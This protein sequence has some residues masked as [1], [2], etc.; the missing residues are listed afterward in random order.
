MDQSEVKNWKKNLVRL[1]NHRGPHWPGYH[2][3]VR[4]LMN[5]ADASLPANASPQQALQALE[6]VTDD[7]S[8]GIADGS[9]RPYEDRLV[10]IVQ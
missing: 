6:G 3:E 5:L 9:I 4:G 7:L 2:D 8:E 1:W 10:R